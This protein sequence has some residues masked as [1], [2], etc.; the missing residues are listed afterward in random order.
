MRKGI[1]K[2]KILN[3]DDAKLIQEFIKKLLKE[4]N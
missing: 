3:D 4:I 1:E 2:D